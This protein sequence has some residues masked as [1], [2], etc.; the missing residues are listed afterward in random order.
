MATWQH[1]ATAPWHLVARFVTSLPPTPPSVDDEIWA[2]SHLSAGE[3]ALW[4]RMSNQDR[5]HSIAVTRRFVARRPFASRPEIAGALLHDVGKIDC[6][7]GTFGRVTATLVGPHLSDRFRSYHDHEMIGA[8]MAVDAGSD[9]ATVDL[10][11]QEG[12]AYPDLERCDH[13]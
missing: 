13:A 5:R 6:S 8:L 9:P 7:L 12:P 4:V 10:I 1:V 11:A 2:E 3:R